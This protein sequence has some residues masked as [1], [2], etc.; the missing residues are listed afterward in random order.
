M[1]GLMTLR[2]L[3]ILGSK[4][5]VTGADFVKTMQ[6][7][8]PNRYQPWYAVF[9]AS[10]GF[11]LAYHQNIKLCGSLVS[12]RNEFAGIKKKLLFFS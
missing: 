12:A 7:Y 2:R 10:S 1:L 11:F 4:V 8:L 3:L 5:K 9:L 6:A